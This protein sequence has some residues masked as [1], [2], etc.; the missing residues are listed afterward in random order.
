MLRI[1]YRLTV[2][3]GKNISML[4]MDNCRTNSNKGILTPR[5]KIN[6]LFLR[7]NQENRFFMVNIRKTWY[8]IRLF[9]SKQ[10]RKKAFGVSLDN[11]P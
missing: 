2:T 4:L 9:S 7:I 10:Y 3:T 6:T 8:T 5:Y 1:N 11:Y